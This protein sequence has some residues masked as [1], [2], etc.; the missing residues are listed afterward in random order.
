MAET[1]K[2]ASRRATPCNA[3]RAGAHRASEALHPTRSS[4][5]L[6]RIARERVPR[7]EN[8]LTLHPIKTRL[9]DASRVGGFDFL[10][11]HFERGTEMAA[12][13]K[14]RINSKTRFVARPGGPM[15]GA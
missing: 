9:V 5:V 2:D 10:G 4:D 12:Q 7:E 8:G 14:H 15:G 1:A 3:G 6:P 13:E 11:Y